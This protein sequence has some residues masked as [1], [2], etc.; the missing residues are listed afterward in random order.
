MENTVVLAD[1]RWVHSMTLQVFSNLKDSVINMN[2]IFHSPESF[3][4]CIPDCQKISTH[5]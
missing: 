5:H 2:S 1:G 3:W 4:E